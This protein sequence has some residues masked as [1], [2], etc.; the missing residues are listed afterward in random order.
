MEGASMPW[1]DLSVREQ[2]RELISVIVSGVSIAAAARRVGVS[3]KTAS[4]WWGR[5]Q[6]DG[7]DGLDDRS[8]ARKTPSRWKTDDAMVDLVLGM[9][10]DHP[11][12]G[13]RKIAARLVRDGHVGVPAASTV[14]AILGRNDQLDDPLRSQRDL[15][16][17]EAAA[18]NDLWQMDFKGD[19][20]LS[21]GGRCYPLT[22]IDDHS[23]YALGLQ[24]FGNQQH[25]TV[26]GALIDILGTVGTPLQ[27]LCDHGPP[28]GASGLARFTGLGVWLIEH[29]VEIIHGRPKHPQTQGKDERFHRTLKND[30]LKTQTNWDN[31]DQVQQAFDTWKAVYNEYRPHEALAMNVPADRY[32]P[33]PRLFNPKPQPPHYPNPQQVRRTDQNGTVQW[34]GHTYRV[35]HAFDRKP[36]YIQPNHNTITISYYTTTIKTIKTNV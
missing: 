4:K 3:R 10:E 20:D 24:A 7:W 17:F 28:W 22:I 27:I 21:E 14:T 15:I 34:Q 19:F 16:R 30:V 9:R 8:H 35:G 5:F 2:R 11:T 29:G 13:G 33:S 18:P 31:L 32:Q 1:N 12:W 25:G 36:V 26:L 6:T 23:R